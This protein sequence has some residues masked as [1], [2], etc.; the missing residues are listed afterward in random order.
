MF[1]YFLQLLVLSLACTTIYV[2][3]AVAGINAMEFE[4]AAEEQRFKHLAEE[5]RC[6][7]CQ[8]QSLA[9]SNAELAQDLRMEVYRL[10][11]QGKTDSE[12]MDY[13]VA[14]YSDF[15]LYRPRLKSSTLIL[16]FGPFLLG[17]IALAVLV[18]HIQRKN[19][20]EEAAI[21]TAERDKLN[22]LLDKNNK[23]NTKDS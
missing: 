18:F 16:W 13:L 19:R 21:S 15:V 5:L 11:K 23:D 9:D 4:N 1:R 7:V 20:P 14:R 22:Q 17:V 2:S 3:S 8:N 6:L 10:M 12:I